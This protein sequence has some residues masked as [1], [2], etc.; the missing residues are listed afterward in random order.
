VRLPS[1]LGTIDVWLPEE[2]ELEEDP[3]APNGTTLVW[4]PEPELGGFSLSYGPA[5]GRSADDL[6]ALERGFADAVEVE[7]DEETLTGGHRV[8]ELRL[9]V[10]THQGR[11]MIE[12][13][14]GHVTHAPERTR[15]EQVRFRFWSEGGNAMRAGYR[16][17]E[18][19]P[20]ELR[21]TLDRI[22]ASVRLVKP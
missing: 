13:R 21:E 10:E 4:A 1:A 22:T 7:S 16:L 2:K 19:A 18:A 9:L 3:G 8:R 6:L 11:A 5:A 12:D 15:R 20:S 17:D 14:P